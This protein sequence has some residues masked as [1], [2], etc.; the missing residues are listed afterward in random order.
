M[1]RRRWGAR[2]EGWCCNHLGKE[3]EREGATTNK[4]E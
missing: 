1:E 3:R 4:G 2:V